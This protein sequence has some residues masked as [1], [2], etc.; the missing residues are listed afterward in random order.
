M[1]KDKSIQ[2]VEMVLKGYKSLIAE[3]YNLNIGWNMLERQKHSA[4]EGQYLSAV[5]MDAQPGAPRHSYK[6]SPILSIRKNQDL[7]DIESEQ[8]FIENR[9]KDI[10]DLLTIIN[11]SLDSLHK[12]DRDIVYWY[13]CERYNIEKIA[14][15]SYL[16]PSKVFKHKHFAL[17]VMY[18]NMKTLE[19]TVIFK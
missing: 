3:R 18:R 14:Q 9:L 12:Q 13:Y 15:M 2:F 11:T 5:N 7:V 16:H 10:D 4:I 6:A 1:D 8:R 19:D 17:R